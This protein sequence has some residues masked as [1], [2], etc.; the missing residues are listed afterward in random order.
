[1]QD[2]NTGLATLDDREITGATITDIPYDNE[3]DAIDA[4]ISKVAATLDKGLIK[5]KAEPKETKD[6]EVSQPS[7][8]TKTTRQVYNL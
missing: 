1:M 5:E 6:E 4:A 3:M 7:T 8:T 2:E